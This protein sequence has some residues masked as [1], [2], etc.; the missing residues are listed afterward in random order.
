MDNPKLTWLKAHIG[1]STK[2]SPSPFAHWLDGILEE[3]E[4]GQLSIRFTVRPDMTN[5]H[6]MLHGGVISGM[7]DDVIGT[8]VATLDKEQPFVSI[9]LSV[10]FV[11]GAR[12]S[13]EVIAKAKVIRNGRTAVYVQAELFNQSAKLL[14]VATSNLVAVPQRS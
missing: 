10:D 8:T 14:A 5:P 11:Q 9:N 1:K 2:N 13:D 12:V 3:V 4:F 7:L 6:G